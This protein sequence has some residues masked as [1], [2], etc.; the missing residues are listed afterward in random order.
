MKLPI[1]EVLL[2]SVLSGLASYVFLEWHHK[3]H[4]KKVLDPIM[5]A[6]VMDAIRRECFS[7]KSLALDFIGDEQF[8][9]I[10]TN[11]SKRS[12]EW[13]N[14]FVKKEKKDE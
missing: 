14:R 8:A 6:P 10:C 5:V 7:T 2:I 4:D 9:L 11:D 3:E 13:K 1:A 12:K